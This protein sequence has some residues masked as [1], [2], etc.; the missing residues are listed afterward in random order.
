VYGFLVVEEVVTEM[1]I[2]I[3]LQHPQRVTPQQHLLTQVVVVLVG[4][5]VEDMEPLDLDIPLQLLSA[6]TGQVEGRRGTII[7]MGI[8]ILLN[9]ILVVNQVDL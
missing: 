7:L 6:V 4:Q 1:D 3:L 8:L 9:R 2:G 5:V